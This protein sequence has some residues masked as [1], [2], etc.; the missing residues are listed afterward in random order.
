MVVKSQVRRRDERDERTGRAVAAVECAIRRRN[1]ETMAVKVETT[2]MAPTIMMMVSS[3]L[4]RRDM[5]L[6]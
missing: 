3:E 1:T 5:N 6:V 2:A 4:L